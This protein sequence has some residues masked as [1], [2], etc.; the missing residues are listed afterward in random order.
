MAAFSPRFDVRETKE[1]Y[2][3]DGD[4]PGIEQKDINIEFTDPHT[5]VISGRTERA[6]EEG[7]PPGRRIE[8]SRQPQ[9]EEEGEETQSKEKGKG[10]KQAGREETA[11][12]QHRY[13]VSER[14]VGEF[15]RSFNFPSNV[16]QENVKASLKHGVLSI[17][18]PKAA[19]PASKRITIE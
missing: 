1:A 10:K 18:V 4:L 2:H 14:S 8:G 3:L 13:W 12:P 11:E 15:S 7:A 16:D 5:L 6:Y 19:P 9:I 17:T